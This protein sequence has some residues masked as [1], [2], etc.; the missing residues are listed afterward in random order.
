ERVL[1]TVQNRYSRS[2]SFCDGVQGHL[3]QGGWCFRPKHS[4]SSVPIARRV[5]TAC[6][7]RRR[8]RGVHRGDPCHSVLPQ[9]LA[10]GRHARK[11]VPLWHTR[12][13]HRRSGPARLGSCP[14]PCANQLL[15]SVTRSPAQ[16]AVPGQRWLPL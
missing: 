2:R 15:L 13:V 11:P 10:G 16:S 4:R 5:E 1:V 3:K 8:P 12:A 6:P 7:P 14:C 9:V